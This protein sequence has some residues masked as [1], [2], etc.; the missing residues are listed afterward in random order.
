MITTP[1]PVAH[2]A[3]VVP[4]FW[5]VPGAPGGVH[6]NTMVLRGAEPVLFDTGIA[7]DREDWLA[8][9]FSVVEPEDVRW[10]VLSHDDP[11]HVGNVEAVMAACPHATLVANWFMC[12]R[13]GP[14]VQLDPLRMRWVDAG[15]SLDVGDRVLQ[16]LRPPIYDS[17]T[18]RVVFDPVSRALW[19][20]DMFAC[21]T[22]RPTPFAEELDADVLAGGFMLFQEALS[23]WVRL[24]QRD[25][26]H[27]VVAELEALGIWSIASTHGPAFRGWMVDEAFSLLHGL[28][29]AAPMQLPGQSVLDEVVAGI[30]G[31]QAA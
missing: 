23:P 22:D 6:M 17:P 1:Y 16:F 10:V 12:E 19:A 4:S 24:A 30:L 31:Q 7:P 13:L 21:P 11:D 9:T 26:W 14:V 3:F 28:P 27:A 25:R 18:T 29:D 5:A 8:A 15:E 2:D 20:G